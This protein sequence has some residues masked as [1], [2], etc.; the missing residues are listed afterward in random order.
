MSKTY[1][2]IDIGK[3]GAIAVISPDGAIT[4]IKM[5][6]IKTELDYHELSSIINGEVTHSGS[7]HVVFEQLGVIFG[8]SKQTA[9]S[10]GEQIGAVEMSCI[11]QGVPYTKVRAVDW[12]KVM[13]QG[14][15]PVTK[16]SVTGKTVVKDTKAMALIAI[17]RLF[18]NLKLT[19]GD[20]AT[21]PHDGLIDA[22]LI[23]EYARRSN[24]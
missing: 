6:L 24:L 1:I 15:A 2:G 4:K 11:C 18:P 16:P 3:N 21:K 14:V 23:A 12:Q 19:F 10:M 17:K 7:V 9:F 5:P 20:K 13:L 8:S 22:V